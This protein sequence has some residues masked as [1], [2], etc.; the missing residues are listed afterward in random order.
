ML[1]S[2]FEKTFLIF[3]G[4]AL[5]LYGLMIPVLSLAGTR[6]AAVITAVR[7][8]N[9]ERGDVFPN[10]YSYAVGFEFVL[11][12]GKVI[13]GNTKIIGNAYSAGIST[14]QTTVMYLPFFPWLNALE[15]GSVFPAGRMIILAFGIL[16]LTFA[17]RMDKPGKRMK[18]QK[19]K[20]IS[21]K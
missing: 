3:I 12:D 11:S 5:I 1:K 13:S 9:G 4:T 8:E 17:I 10:R 15:E 18:R 2:R 7:R 20:L 14:G 19:S 16:F 21:S 6:T